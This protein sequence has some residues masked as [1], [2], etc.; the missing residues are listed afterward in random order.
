MI[1]DFD[2]FCTWMFVVVDDLWQQLAPLYRRPGPAPACSDSELLTLFLV[3]ECCGWDVETEALSRWQSYR[4]LFPVLPSQSRANRR[5]R[6]LALAFNQVRQAVVQLLDLAYD[7]QV[8]IDSLPVPVIQG[9]RVQLATRAWA[10]AGATF[11]RVATKRQLI[12]GYKLH[13][14]VTLNGVIVDFVLAPANESDVAVGCDLL[15]DHT[16]LT[17]GGDKGYISGMRQ[18]ALRAHNQ[19]TLVT[20]TRRSQKQQVSATATRV[21]NA[22]RQSIET[23][24]GQL[25][26]QFNIERNH[27]HSFWGLCTRLYTKLTA[28]TLCIYLNRILGNP[29]FLRIKHLAFP[30]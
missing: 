10:A 19:V 18:A 24:N 26:Q 29:D 28:H 5:R 6:A 16:D 23:V 1:A 25:A 9:T 20:G 2:D 8:A 7:R 11:G 21:I 14:L 15:T 17:V 30:I 12:F 3:A 13:L 27:A 22:A 4:Q